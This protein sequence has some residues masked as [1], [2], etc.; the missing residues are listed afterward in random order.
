MYFQAEDSSSDIFGKQFPETM[1]LL[2]MENDC[3]AS[4]EQ[5]LSEL[6]AQD[7]STQQ[8]LDT[9]I[10]HITSLTPKKTHYHTQPPSQFPPFH[11]ICLQPSTSFTLEV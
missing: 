6:Q 9:L 7:V 5:A 3:I 11:T 4:L 8:K 10:T 2:V 1:P